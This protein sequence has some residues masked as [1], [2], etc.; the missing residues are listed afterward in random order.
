MGWC[1]NMCSWHELGSYKQS[2][3]FFF[4]GLLPWMLSNWLFNDTSG[5][6]ADNWSARPEWMVRPTHTFLARRAILNHQVQYIS[7]LSPLEDASPC[8]T[9]RVTGSFAPLPSSKQIPFTANLCP[10]WCTRRCR[11]FVPTVHE[12]PHHAFQLRCLTKEKR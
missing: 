6:E 7:Y 4:F 8:L 1:L 10:E 11:T 12:G 5:G 9:H 3:F 2:F